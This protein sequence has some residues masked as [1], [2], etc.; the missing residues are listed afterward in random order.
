LLA[1]ALLA[2]TAFAA[3]LVP[4]MLGSLKMTEC[5]LDSLNQAFLMGSTQYGW[6]GV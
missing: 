5:R 3:Y 4:A 2:F 1:V 6:D